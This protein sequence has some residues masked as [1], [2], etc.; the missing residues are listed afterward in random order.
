MSLSCYLSYTSVICRVG[1]LDIPFLYFNVKS[2]PTAPH[3]TVCAVLLIRLFKTILVSN[4]I[5]QLSNAVHL[6]SISTPCATSRI[7]TSLSGLSKQHSSS[8]M[9]YIFPEIFNFMKIHT[10]SVITEV[11]RKISYCIYYITVY[12]SWKEE[13][14]CLTVKS[15]S[16]YPIT[17]SIYLL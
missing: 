10:N 12:V 16:N 9:L 11:S 17:I 1:S 5:Y 13:K 8:S 7:G 2:L 15:K 14:P 6:H 3:R 4:S